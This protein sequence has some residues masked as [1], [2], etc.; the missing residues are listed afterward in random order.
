MRPVLALLAVALLTLSLG[1]CG[2]KGAPEIPE[3][4]VYPRTYPHIPMP[5]GQNQRKAEPQ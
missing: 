4:S 5:A 3:D 1:A 2:R